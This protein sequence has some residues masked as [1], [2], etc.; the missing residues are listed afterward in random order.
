MSEVFVAR[1][2]LTRSQPRHW[3]ISKMMAEQSSYYDA[4]LLGNS[5]NQDVPAD[6]SDESETSDQDRSSK[7]RKRPMNVT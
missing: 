1:L 7:K 4:A 6:Q 5:A 2:D 3:T